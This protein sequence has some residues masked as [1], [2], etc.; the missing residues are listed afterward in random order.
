MGDGTYKR[1]RRDN[2]KTVYRPGK[3][4]KGLIVQADKTVY[5]KMPNG[6]LVRMGK[7]EERTGEV[8]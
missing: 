2:R 5:R 8:M 6:S 7:L 4:G 1:T 3:L